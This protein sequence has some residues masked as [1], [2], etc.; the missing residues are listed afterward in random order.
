[1]T[2]ADLFTAYSGS[3]V[4]GASVIVIQGGAVIERRAFGMADL[5]RRVPATP[6]TDY[7]LASVSKQFTAMAVML[8][9]R[10]GKLRYDQSVRDF[11]PELP[12]SAGGVTVRHLLNHTSGL[13]DYEG[14][15]P[16]SRTTQLDD[17]DVLAL[18]AAK[19]SVYFPAG[20]QYR[21][22]NSGYVLLGLIVARVSGMSFPSFLR[23]RIFEPLSMRA[24]V[25]H[26]E[27]A[28]TIPHR[29]YGYSPRGGGFVQTDQSVTSATLGDGGIYTNVDDMARW[30]LALYGAE[31]VDS[32][33]LD[34][35]TTPPQLPAG[36]ETQYG[37]GWFV[38]SY[39]GEK[40]WRHTGETSGFRNAI[41]RFPRRR[42]TI[43]V[44]TNRS[45][46]EPAA[47]A[48]RIADRLLFR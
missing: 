43:I 39:R 28:D 6:E 4:P 32:A 22:S 15:I 18:L 46:G 33:T 8:L 21:Y 26:V 5:E 12:A 24:T 37:F 44:L 48:E 3:A 42:L 34:L 31:L 25:M 20:T 29:A 1:M 27:G 38:D 19:D 2:V 9:A 47:I 45:S 36:A 23:A 40:R 7:R 10:D 35:A 17:S 30:D 13:Y 16:E 14:L 11:L 41:Q